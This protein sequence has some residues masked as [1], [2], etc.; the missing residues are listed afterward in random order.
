VL[1]E[2]DITVGEEKTITG[3][4]GKSWTF[5]P[6][7]G[8]FPIDGKVVDLDWQVPEWVYVMNQQP[9]PNNRPTIQGG[10]GRYV[11]LLGN[12]YIIH[13]PP[14]EDSPLKGAKPGSI[15]ASEEDLKAIWPRIH[16]GTPVYVF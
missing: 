5:V 10:A 11:I 14:S 15:M 2:G 16:A 8:A 12:G 4:N 1:R 13:S 9:V 7:K 3:Q 6:V